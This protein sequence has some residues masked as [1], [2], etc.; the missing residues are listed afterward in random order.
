MEA[1]TT[2]S[3]ATSPAAPVDFISTAILSWTTLT[4]F[5]AG[6]MKTGQLREYIREFK[7]SL[8]KRIS[9]LLD[10]ITSLL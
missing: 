8:K 4:Q 1:S 10:T 5:L 2:T 7:V 3:N 6:D 9:D